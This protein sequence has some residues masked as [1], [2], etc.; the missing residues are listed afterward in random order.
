LL[1]L[2]PE[3]VFAQAVGFESLL[4]LESLFF[5]GYWQ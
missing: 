3:R 2:E 5:E 1:S 4:F